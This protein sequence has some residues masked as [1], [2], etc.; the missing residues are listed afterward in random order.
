MAGL[1]YNIID[2]Y[3]SKKCFCKQNIIV[4]GTLRKKNLSLFIAYCFV[5]FY[6]MY[7]RIVTMY[8]SN[9]A[10]MYVGVITIITS[11]NPFFA[12][13]VDYIMYRVRMEYFH[14][15]GMVVIVL[16]SIFI[17]MKE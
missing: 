2:M 10:G 4:D 8:F 6:V 7:M 16:G 15:L 13:F 3:Q 5:Y 9:K 11:I 1:F 12:A 17:C 14:F